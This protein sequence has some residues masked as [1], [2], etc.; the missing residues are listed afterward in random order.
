MIIEYP[1]A[2]D[3]HKIKLFTTTRPGGVS[4]GNYAS[5]NVSPFCGDNP[6][7]VKHNL[8]QLA[9]KINI[10]P[11]KILIPYQVHGTEV[12]KIDDAFMQLDSKEQTELLHGIDALVTNITGV[13]IGVTT[14]DCVPVFLYDTTKQ[15][16]AVAHA[17]WRGTCAKIVSKTIH[18][19]L[20]EY[21]C[22]PEDIQAVIGPSI[23]VQA[24]QV[25][26]ELYTAFQEAGFPVDGIFTRRDTGLYVNLWKTNELLLLS[27]G[28]VSSNIVNANRCTYT[29]HEL[30]FSARRLGV[31]SGRMLSGIYIHV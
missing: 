10:S 18:L 19:M 9:G 12:R 3:H 27:E 11:E 26:E 13:C 17:G 29:E 15:A 30:F 21:N 25:G 8:Q 28:V 2:K 20:S 7:H 24:Y 16:V 31:K 6:E 22:K 23:S 14:A 4:E 1:S 5:L